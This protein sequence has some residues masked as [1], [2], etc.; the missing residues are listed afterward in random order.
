M[1]HIEVGGHEGKINHRYC[2]RV[3]SIESINDLF[4]NIANNKKVTDYN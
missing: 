1:N 3:I 4:I 2:C